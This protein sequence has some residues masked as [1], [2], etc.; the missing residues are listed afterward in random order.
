[1]IQPRNFADVNFVVCFVA[2]K[3]FRLYKILPA[4]ISFLCVVSLF[5]SLL[6]LKFVK[7]ISNS[8]VLTQS[9]VDLRRLTLK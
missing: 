9:I 6:I 1:M 8:N 3:E 4:D 5:V 2:L 7:C